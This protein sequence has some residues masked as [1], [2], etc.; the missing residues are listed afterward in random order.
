M[1]VMLK[2]SS[3]AISVRRK[4]PKASGFF[5]YQIKIKFRISE[6]LIV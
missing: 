2:N 1:Q 6:K 5:G 3:V 4:Y